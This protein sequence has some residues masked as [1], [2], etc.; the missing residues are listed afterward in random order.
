M[1]H[2]IE[3]D[4]PESTRLVDH[5]IAEREANETIQAQSEHLPFL[6]QLV[7]QW[8]KAA[9][10]YNINLKKLITDV[11]RVANGLG[12]PRKLLKPTVREA[13]TLVQE[14][15]FVIALL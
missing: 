3:E 14:K 2:S 6:W 11:E 9:E 1:G 5:C 10:R 13:I 12:I 4:L 15:G 8:E 7:H